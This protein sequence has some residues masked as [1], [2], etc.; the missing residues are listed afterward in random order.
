MFSCVKC[1]GG[2]FESILVIR[3]STPLITKY[4]VV[5]VEISQ[6]S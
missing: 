4:V 6:I 3:F 2:L 5:F 1:R